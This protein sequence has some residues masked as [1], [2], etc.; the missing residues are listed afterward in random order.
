ML[1]PKETSRK[2]IS[3]LDLTNLNDD[4]TDEDVIVLCQKAQTPFGNTAAVCIWKEFISVAKKELANT[5]I[6]IATVVNFP[7]GG[8]NTESVLDEVKFAIDKGAKTKTFALLH[9]R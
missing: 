8:T 6:K 2:A 4:C 1:D 5:P 9:S 3:L 7:H